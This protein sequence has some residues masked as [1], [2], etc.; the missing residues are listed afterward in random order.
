MS[1]PSLGYCSADGE[2]ERFCRFVSLRDTGVGG[3]RELAC[4]V[5]DVIFAFWGLGSKLGSK[6]GLGFICSTQDLSVPPLLLG[7]H[8]AGRTEERRVETCFK[9]DIVNASYKKSVSAA[10]ELNKNEDRKRKGRRKSPEGFKL[11]LYSPNRAL[12]DFVYCSEM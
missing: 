7:G 9:S 1:S 10:S 8:G 4:S 5:G 3:L 11:V 6:F 2:K 12:E